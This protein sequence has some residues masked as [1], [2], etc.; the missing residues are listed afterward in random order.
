MIIAGFAR[1]SLIDYPGK[2][3][4]TV[5][6]SGCNLRCPFCHNPD[7]VPMHSKTKVS[8]KELFTYFEK[9]KNM[10]DG[11]C[12]TGGEPT[13]QKGLL[14]F[15]MK[16]KALGLKV[17]LDT[18][19][20]KPDVIEKLIPLVDYIAMDIKSSKKGYIKMGVSKEV[21]NF[22]LKSISIIMSSGIK[23][24]FR[25]TAVPGIL[26][27]E[28]VKEIVETI[29]GAGCY[30]I[31]QFVPAERM[32]DESFKVKPYTAEELLEMQKIAAAKVKR[33]MIRNI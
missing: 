20:T 31:Q 13:L 25:S 19:G 23:Y 14:D 3:V 18:N 16:V 5:F 1:N 33:C 21:L 6:T 12:V 28:D 2:I 17:K 7:L 26:S 15:V 9:Y 27:V 24:E 29:K 8:E 11:V 30:C 10:L 4:S 22:I 32:V